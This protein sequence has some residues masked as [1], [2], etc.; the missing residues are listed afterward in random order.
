[1]RQGNVVMWRF[2][3]TCALFLLILSCAA[4]AAQKTPKSK[5]PQR[6]RSAKQLAKLLNAHPPQ[7]VYNGPI[8]R[9]DGPT[10]EVLSAMNSPNA[11]APQ[12]GGTGGDAQY[13]GTNVQVDGVDEADIVKSDG[14][15][16]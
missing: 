4:N 7:Y 8:F 9:V 11:G 12:T 16:I 3:R 14:E 1:M 6:L 15:F 10:V 5:Q 13:S 2:W